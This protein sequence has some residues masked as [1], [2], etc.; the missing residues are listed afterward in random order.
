MQEV[1]SRLCQKFHSSI[2]ILIE[3]GIQLPRSEPAKHNKFAC[4]EKFFITLG[5]QFV[6]NRCLKES[7]MD[8]VNNVNMYNLILVM[9][10]ESL[11]V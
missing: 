2:K 5:K 3:E 1:C 8:S 6:F 9:G 7:K 4:R 11:H 10:K